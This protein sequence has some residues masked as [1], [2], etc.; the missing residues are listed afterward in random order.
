MAS[1]EVE[2]DDGGRLVVVRPR[3]Q[4][5]GDRFV[6]RMSAVVRANPA[7]G[8][9]AFLYDLRDYVGTVDHEAVTRFAEAWNTLPEP[10]A[11]RTAFVTTDSG[12]ELWARVFDV[13]F[14]GREHRIFLTEDHAR[15]WLG[16]PR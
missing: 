14:L 7:L 5:D 2:L 16:V 12:F 6:E 9:Y 3:G 8:G 4:V 13:L 1:I 15:A 11:G 10:R